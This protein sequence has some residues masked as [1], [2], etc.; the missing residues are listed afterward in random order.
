MI[1][2]ADQVI[3]ATERTVDVLRIVSLLPSAT[4]IV[5]ALGARDA[6]VAVSHEC[7]WPAGIS[8]LPVVTESVNPGDNSRAIDQ[9]VRAS[10]DQA[11]SIY[12]INHELLST[13]KPDVVITQDLCQVCAVPAA[14]VER[15]LH[16]IVDDAEVQLL[17]LSPRSLK[18]VFDD[19]QRVATAIDRHCEARLVQAEL[20]DRLRNLVQNGVAR[21]MSV[22]A[23]EWLDPVML[24]GLW[25]PELIDL[26][27]GVSLLAEAGELAPTVD[28][29]RLAQIDPE[30]VL[31]KPCGYRLS[32][33]E[34]EIDTI[35]SLLSPDWSAVA[36][37]Q[38]FVV[39]G[40]QYFNRSGPRLVDSAELLHGLITGRRD[41]DW[42]SR[43]SADVAEV[44]NLE[45]ASVFSRLKLT[46]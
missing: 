19:I 31:V 7:D 24:G 11:L 32:D 36:N 6:L 10:L 43:F 14:A 13:L 26:A 44:K 15:A 27:G 30:L 8:A 39:D 17:R 33:S 9:R 34:A 38:V 46:A 23:I 21:P 37:E 12:R 5:C 16:E 22:L 1:I 3:C 29:A 42:Y 35:Q 4:E 2:D 45:G 28:A 20:N 18:D 25:T 41:S 40:N